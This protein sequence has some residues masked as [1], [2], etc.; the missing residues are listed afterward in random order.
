M[1]VRFE[2]RADTLDTVPL[3]IFHRL[4]DLAALGPTAEIV[5][6]SL[7]VAW[8]NCR[9]AAAGLR[10]LAEACRR[11]ARACRSYT[12]AVDRY[13]RALDEPHRRWAP[14]FPTREPWMEYGW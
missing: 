1:A 8:L 11:R 12:A 10:E 9:G 2:R 14:T 6:Q 7:Q 5:D 4:T 3:A 13:H